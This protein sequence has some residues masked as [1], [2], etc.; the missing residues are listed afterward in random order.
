MCIGLFI[1]Y[2][3]STPSS[4]ASADDS[5]WKQ[6]IRL[7]VY[8]LNNSYTHNARCFYWESYSALIIFFNYTEIK[9]ISARLCRHAFR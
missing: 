1:T 8:Q 7:N 4:K 3:S 2:V 9:Q 5:C 6:H